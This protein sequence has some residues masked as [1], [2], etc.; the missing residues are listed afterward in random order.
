MISKLMI[1]F[2][3]LIFSVL[4]LVVVWFVS[5]DNQT[6]RRGEAKTESQKSE[7]IF[8]N[9]EVVDYTPKTNRTA[10]HPLQVPTTRRFPIWSKWLKA[11]SWLP[12]LVTKVITGVQGLRQSTGSDQAVTT[13]PA[14][15]PTPMPA[16][17][18]IPTPT[19]TPAATTI[20]SKITLESFLNRIF[21]SLNTSLGIT[22][23]T[24]S[25][26]C[27][28]A[29]YDPYDYKI[30]VLYDTGFFAKLGV[31]NKISTEVANAVA[32]E[33]RAHQETLARAAM[34]LMPNIKLTGGY[35]REYYDYPTISS[36]LHINTYC[37]WANFA[38]TKYGTNY[39]E[40]EIAAFIW[41]PDSL[42]SSGQKDGNLSR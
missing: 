10:R 41:T 17:T 2:I 15:A 4:L 28:V 12:L 30:K 16:P 26:D 33:L 31:S 23:F 25:I 35:Y 42:L 3:G 22:H 27:N 11:I 8:M 21:S 5:R 29:I 34:A 19:S 40:A 18:L 36:G 13:I 6:K 14:I 1:I 32:S 37:S 20:T 38:P 9:Q 24:F 39:T 7:I